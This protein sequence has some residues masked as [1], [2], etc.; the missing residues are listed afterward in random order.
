MSNPIVVTTALGENALLFHSMSGS[1]QL[2]RLSEFRVQLLSKNG[3]LNASEL[4]G[5]PLTVALPL[6]KGTRFFYGLVTQ[7]SCTGWIHDYVSYEAVVHPWLWLLKRTSNCEIYQN[8]TVVEIVKAV[9]EKGC[10]AGVSHLSTRLL[11]QQ[12]PSLPYCVQYRETDFDFVCRL[13][14]DAGIYFYFTYEEQQ[15]C[16]VLA[17]SY[18]AH[19][20]IA[21]YQNLKFAGERYHNALREESVAEWVVSAEIHSSSYVLN[22]FDYEHAQGSLNG[23]LR[24]TAKIKSGGAA[25]SFEH[26]DYPGKYDTAATGETLALARMEREHGL[27]EV[28]Q[29]RSNARGLFPGGLFG[30]C[31]HPR[32]DQN[33]SYLITSAQYQIG[34]SSYANLSG[35]H[36]ASQEVDVECRFCAIGKNHAFR[37]LCTIAKPKVQGPQTA[38]VVGNSGEEI[39]TD[40]QGRIKVQF[41]WD[42]VGQN[43]DASSCWVRVAQDFAGKGW[44]A[45]FVPRVGMEVVVSFLEGDPDRPLITGCVYNSDTPLPYELP[46]NQ[47]QSGIK[48]HSTPNGSGFNEL[49]FEDKAG[50][51]ELFMHAEKDFT[52]VVKN[53]V[54]DTIGNNQTV[55]ISGDQSITVDKT[56]TI[57]ATS[58]IELKV[59]SSTI[60]IEP[61]KIT[62]NSMQIDLEAVTTMVIKGGMVEIN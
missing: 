50:N 5:T 36:I 19:S 51:E 13:L 15:H 27:S 48:T 42:R 32:E 1:E 35:S 44:G 62:I 46:A 59:G 52:R 11:S 16:M 26:F 31:D 6:P 34:I 45:L 33:G 60:K 57:T 12:Y 3:E 39:H 53:D 21:D 17:D 38:I 47:T 54:T 49:R 37:P 4:L 30:L 24:S 14:E 10:Y 28:I 25:H 20:A 8:K 41:H 40:A 56:I 55:T 43:D 61:T 7:F 2:G 22:D 18:T 23:G 58:S 9:C 29:A